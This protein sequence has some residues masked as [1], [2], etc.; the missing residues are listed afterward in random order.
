[1]KS[2]KP[3]ITL[4]KLLGE[5]QEALE[6]FANESLTLRIK[7][8]SIVEVLATLSHETYSC[9]G[10]I[11]NFQEAF[12]KALESLGLE[13]FDELKRIN[14][15][16]NNPQ[17]S[18]DES[19]KQLRACIEKEVLILKLRN[20]VALTLKDLSYHER[21][22]LLLVVKQQLKTEESLSLVADYEYTENLE[23]ILLEII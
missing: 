13:A 17:P 18:S 6:G 8:L 12:Q 14:L 9:N 7:E 3:K 21:K 20:L 2:L 1:M 23:E 5:G 11:V 15:S 16:S 19:I 22:T 4:K 10:Y